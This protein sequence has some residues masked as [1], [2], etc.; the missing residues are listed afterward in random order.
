M[1]SAGGEDLSALGSALLDR[2]PAPFVRRVAARVIDALTVLATLWAAIVMHL[3]WF[4]GDLSD[5]YQ[6]EPWGRWFVT[7]VS[8]VTL[9]GIYEWAFLV[10]SKGQTPG[11]DI[12]KVRVTSTHGSPEI[13]TAQAI[14]RWLPLGAVAM[15]TNP[16][17]VI[18]G[19]AVTSLPAV[20][21][22]RRT[23]LDVVARTRVVPYDRDH[24]D[25][26]ARRPKPRWRRRREAREARQASQE[27]AGR[28]S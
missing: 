28:P 3:L 19:L 6:P 14:G 17:L 24:E 23:L 9:W 1:G 13:S 27:T 20:R 4:F 25:P 12:M 16:L 18:V 2:P 8:Y 21:D 5:R 11:K 22:D 15:A 26:S 7:T 10:H